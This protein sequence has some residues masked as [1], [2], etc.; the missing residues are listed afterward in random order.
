MEP[1]RQAFF[2][3]SWRRWQF[4]LFAGIL[5]YAVIP[6]IE[7]LIFR[8]YYQRRLAEDWGNGPAIIGTACFFTFAHRQYLVA[9]AYNIT[10][11]ALPLPEQAAVLQGMQFAP[12]G[13]AWKAALAKG[14]LAV[15]TTPSQQ[16]AF[17]GD[18]SI[19]DMQRY[20]GVFFKKY[21]PVYV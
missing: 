4:W 7:E 16:A 15:R 10:M 17:L 1:W 3:M 14:D 9:N 5:S 6:I 13:K 20:Y 18:T 21:P 19:G 12:N 2:D 11:I 8:G